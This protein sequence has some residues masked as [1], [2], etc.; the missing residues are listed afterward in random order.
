MRGKL[1]RSRPQNRVFFSEPEDLA[2]PLLDLDR[3]VH[4]LLLLLLDPGRRP[5]L[6]P[7]PADLSDLPIGQVPARQNPANTRIAYHQSA[8]HNSISTARGSASMLHQPVFFFL[9][10]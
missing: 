3:A 1:P 7:T 10:F 8:P 9:S 6:R 5:T 2:R 4:R